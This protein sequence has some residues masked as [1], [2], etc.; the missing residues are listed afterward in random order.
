MSR[1]G[2]RTGGFWSRRRAS[3]WGGSTRSVWPWIDDGRLISGD[4][5]TKEIPLHQAFYDTRTATGAVVHLHSSHSVAW[6]MLPEVNPDNVLPPLTAYCIIR[7]RKV[8]L[9]PVLVPSDPAMGD[10]IRGLASKRAAVLL[11]NHGPVV[12]GRDL[13]SAVNAMEELEETA[14]LT[15]LT[16]GLSPKL[17]SDVEARAVFM[18]FNVEWD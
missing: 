7:L 18:K 5:P 16:R 13:E 9:L 4:A 1:R 2:C 17:L 3:V 11:A 6:S 12:A 10:T 15:L 14:K 8:K